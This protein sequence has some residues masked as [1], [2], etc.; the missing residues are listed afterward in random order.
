MIKF[1]TFL[2][3]I[4]SVSVL[5]KEQVFFPTE[6]GGRIQAD[7]FGKGE[8]GVILAHGGRFNKDT[9]T[10]QVDALIE[11]GFTV[12]AL[13]FRG[14]G[15]SRGPGDE[16][17]MDAPLYK[18]ILGAAEFMKEKG[19]KTVSVLGA[20]LGA[21][22]AMDAAIKA[23]EK[24][25]CL[26]LLAGGGG[27]LPPEQLQGRKLF[28]IARNDPGSDGRLRM[29]TLMPYYKK[30]PEPKRLQILEGSAHAQF[31]FQTDQAQSVL[32]E[33]IEFLKAPK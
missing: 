3:A 14:Y 9:W 33:I 25:R 23:P 12:L 26:V 21:G 6:D 17:V 18:D 1:F 13:N 32:K 5:A 24:F 31:L 30:V 15:L 28:L 11:A 7:I 8:H 16:A 29:D 10:N 2:I 22:A 4:L 27:A 19:V 20:S